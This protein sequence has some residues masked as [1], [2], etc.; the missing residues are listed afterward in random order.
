MQFGSSEL[1]WTAGLSRI[2]GLFGVALFLAAPVA[3]QVWEVGNQLLALETPQAGA[4]LGQVMVSGDF[5][6]DGIEDLAIGA[7]YWDSPWTTQAGRVEVFLGSSTRTLVHSFSISE[8]GADAAEAGFSLAAGDFDGDGSDE[9]AVGEPLADATVSGT[10]YQDAGQVKIFKYFSGIWVEVSFPFGL[11][12]A[13]AQLGRQLAAGD[14]N[15]DGYCD[16]A[17]SAPYS[18]SCPVVDCF[19]DQDI[20]IVYGGADG[21]DPQHL[22][23]IFSPSPTTFPDGFGDALAAGDFDDDGYD[24]LAVAAPYRTVSGL[25]SAGAVEV[26]SGSSN[27]LD[28]SQPQ[29]LHDS[30][31]PD[32]TS[33][34][35]QEFGLSLATAYFDDPVLC[36]GLSH[37]YADLAIGVPGESVGGQT[38]AGKVMVAYGSSG[39]IDTLRDTRI[40]ANSVGLDPQAFDYFGWS[41]AAGKAHSGPLVR[42]E[43][44]AI[45][46]QLRDVYSTNDGMVAVVFGPF[47]ATNGRVP[48]QVVGQQPGFAVS[49]ATSGDHFGYSVAIGD[50]DGDGSG[51]LAVGVP[52]KGSSDSGVVQVLYGALFADGFESG[53][54]GNWSGTSP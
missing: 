43:D 49:P 27:G 16:L 11:E 1:R 3:A 21:L 10:T 15:G 46:A 14:F 18:V 39:G 26:F 45:G 4:Y 32:G 17:M 35:G 6:G 50:F 34:A 22:Q 2:K 30:S 20:A 19:Y 37:C 40:D 41:V 54:T 33:A 48:A 7:P 47:S 9:L 5:N 44:L 13:G 52:H 23:I 53:G 8:V 29:E 12:A 31:F 36:F 42:P 25:Q 28:S 51:D 38:A 24:D